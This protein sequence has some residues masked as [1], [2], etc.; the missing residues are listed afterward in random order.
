M[1][2]KYALYNSKWI[3]NEFESNVSEQNSMKFVIIS[4][5]YKSHSNFQILVSNYFLSLITSILSKF[6]NDF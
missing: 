4:K 6:L 3:N 1:K 2:I 5:N